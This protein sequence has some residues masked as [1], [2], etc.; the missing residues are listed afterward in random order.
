MT[1]RAIAIRFARHY[2]HAGFWSKLAKQAVTAGRAACHKAL[3]LYYA[4]LSPDTPTWAKATIAG[5]LGYFILP[6]DSIP[7]IIPVLGY[8]DD[9][10]ALAFATATVAAH[11]TPEHVEKADDTLARWFDGA[12]PQPE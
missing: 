2:S 6:I 8:T 7:D 9:L 12:E 3:C 11:I 5:A 1:T 4:S 10:T